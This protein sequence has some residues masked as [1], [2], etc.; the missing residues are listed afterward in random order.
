[1]MMG[2]CDLSLMLAV[3][4]KFSKLLPISQGRCERCQVSINLGTRSSF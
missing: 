4:R 3:P 1:M 2:I